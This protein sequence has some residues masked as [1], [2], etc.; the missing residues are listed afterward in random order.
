MV[1]VVNRATG[2]TEKIKAEKSVFMDIP[3]VNRVAESDIRVYNLE[4]VW[5]GREVVE[6]DLSAYLFRG[7]LLREADFRKQMSAMDWTEFRDK[8]VAVHC[9]TDAVVPRWSYVLVAS[10]AAPYARSVAFG[11]AEALVRDFYTRALELEDWAQYD[12][13]IVVIKGCGSDIVPVNAYITATL[14]LQER[15]KKIMYGEPCSSV[16]IWRKPRNVQVKKP[17]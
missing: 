10:K 4:S 17:T 13:R 2:L 14:K 7:L 8:H 1:A 5:D 6:I 9:S 12:D 11:T 16:P 3:I 15:A